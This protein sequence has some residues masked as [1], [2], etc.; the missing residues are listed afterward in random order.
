MQQEQLL[1]MSNIVKDMV[2]TIQKDIELNADNPAL[3]IMYANVLLNMGKEILIQSSGPDNTYKTLKYF[4][5]L[6]EQEKNNTTI[7]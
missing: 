6:V 7:H 4:T 1:E 2:E 5:D 3:L